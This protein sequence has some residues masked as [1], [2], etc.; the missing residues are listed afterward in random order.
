MISIPMLKHNLKACLIPFIIILLFLV[1]YTSVIIYMYDPEIAKMFDAYR[2]M[3]P[4]MM[5][6]MGMEGMASSLLEWIKVYLYGF[7]M[8]LF[9]LIFIIIAVNKLVMGFIDNGSLAGILAT[10][11][12]RGKIIVTQLLSLYM[13]L[14]IL[15]ACVTAV[16]L[17]SANAMFP[18]ELDVEKYLCLNAGTLMLW[19]AVAGITFLAA[20]IFSDAKYYYFFGAGIPILFFFLNMLGNMG[21][22]LEFLK[23][24]TIYSLLPADKL[25]AGNSEAVLPCMILLLI[26]VVLSAA[27]GIWFTKRDLSL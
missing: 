1:M 22:D 12:S 7:I 6:A 4:E 5:A 11:N 23:Y 19:F 26:S 20:C 21:E 3:M 13:W 16:G 9:P 27:G 14:F 24:T 17:V 10:P 15:M 18:D 25:I 8:L 2:E